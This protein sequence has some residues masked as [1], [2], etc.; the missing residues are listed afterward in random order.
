MA[1]ILIVDDDAGIRDAVSFYIR[2]EG[3]DVV[4]VSDGVE[5]LR[6]YQEGDFDL[7]I[8]DI[9]MPGHGGFEVCSAIRD[10]DPRI[11]V[12]FLSVKDNLIDKK[13]G[14]KLGADDYITKPFEPTELVLRVNSCLRRGQ[15]L[16]RGRPWRHK[17][18]NLAKRALSFW[19]ICASIPTRAAY[20]S[21][22]GASISPRK[23][24]TFCS[25]WRKAPTRCSRASKFS[26]RCGAP[27]TAMRES[28]PFS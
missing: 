13:L 22:T 15:Y 11:P 10:K 26:T 23:S 21:R 7:V 20:P 28:W 25:C 16:L 19:G 14:F 17:A 9:M 27:I 2:K 18:A 12:I 1:R 8:L 4:A 24:T 5:A 6:V 3:Y